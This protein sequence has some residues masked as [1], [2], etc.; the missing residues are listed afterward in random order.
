M[1]SGILLLDKPAGLTSF[2]VVARSRKMLGTRRVGHLGTLDPFATGILPLA[3]GKATRLSQ[4]LMEHDKRYLVTLELGLATDTMDREGKVVGE[5][6]LSPEHLQRLLQDD[7]IMIKRA[8][9]DLEG[10]GKQLPPMYSA[11]KIEGKPLYKYARR[12]EDVNRSSRHIEVY[13][14]SLLGVR[15]DRSYLRPERETLVLD[16]MV[17]CSKGTY[18]RVLASELGQML[19]SLAYAVALRRL[20]VGSFTVAEALDLAQ[21]EDLFSNVYRA[22]SAAWCSHL[23]RQGQILTMAEAMSEY[24]SYRLNREE[25]LAI[26]A[27][28]AICC[29]TPSAEPECRSAAGAVQRTAEGRLRNIVCLLWQDDLLAVGSVVEQ[30][31]KFL[32]RPETVFV[33][34][35]E[36]I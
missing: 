28:M 26:S 32:I 13:Q 33:T 3:F 20:S 34:R 35:A 27:G 23:A 10:A 24:P 19:G 2:G 4:Y 14:A 22:D 11:V 9:A 21:A 31:E 6:Q 5:K 8:V 30:G 16:L 17:Y 18:I 36:I 7:C 12:G 29:H 1:E 25:A 15:Q